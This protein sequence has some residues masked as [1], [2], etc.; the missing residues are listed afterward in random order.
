MIA[1]FPIM[2]VSLHKAAADGREKRL[3]IVTSWF[4]AGKPASIEIGN[5][6]RWC[7]DGRC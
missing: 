4:H 2:L 1:A 3:P 5:D 7:R 6:W